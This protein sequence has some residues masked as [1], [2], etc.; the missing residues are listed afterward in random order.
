MGH[1]SISVMAPVAGSYFG[2]LTLRHPN[3]PGSARTIIFNAT[4]V[5]GPAAPLPSAPA[6]P[7]GSGASITDTSGS[8]LDPG[9]ILNPVLSPQVSMVVE[10]PKI[11]AAEYGGVDQAIKDFSAMVAK[12]AGVDDPLYVTATPV[13]SDNSTSLTINATVKPGLAL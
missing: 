13:E 8:A 9:P 3:V 6:A 10:F 1:I 11:N 12:V 4:S 2:V 7:I 5:L